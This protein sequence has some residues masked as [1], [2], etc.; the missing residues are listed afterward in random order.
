MNTLQLMSDAQTI[1]L[2]AMKRD[3]H[4]TENEGRKLARA[5]LALLKEA[6]KMAVTIAELRK[7]LDEETQHG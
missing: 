4:L 7:A 1:A 3:G 6:D 2:E 5:F